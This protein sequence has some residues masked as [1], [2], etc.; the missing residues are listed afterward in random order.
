[1]YRSGNL[2][3]SDHLIQVLQVDGKMAIDFN[4]TLR[5]KYKIT[6]ELQNRIRK[7]GA[8]GLPQ[9]LFRFA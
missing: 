8:G 6:T 4:G 1:M 5:N 7:E 2:D 9:R 3:D